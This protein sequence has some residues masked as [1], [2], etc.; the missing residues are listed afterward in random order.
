[1]QT[2]I[3]SWLEFLIHQVC[4]GLGI[5]VSHTCPNVELAWVKSLLQRCMVLALRHQA[6]SPVRGRRGLKVRQI[7]CRETL[8]RAKRIMAPTRAGAMG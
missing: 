1:M 5:C 8:Q 3:I 2:Q 6:P 4:Q 7:S